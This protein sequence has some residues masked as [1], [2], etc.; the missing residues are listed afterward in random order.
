P[1]HQ[2]QFRFAPGIGAPVL[3]SYTDW[4]GGNESRLSIAYECQQ[5]W[6]CL[7]LFW[8]AMLKACSFALV[9]AGN[10]IAARM[11]IMAITTNSSIKVKPRGAPRPPSAVVRARQF[12][13]A[14]SAQTFAFI[15]FSIAVRWSEHAKSR[16]L[17]LISPISAP[18]D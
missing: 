9:R 8:H 11:A 5:I 6:S 18:F 16:E 4:F 10:N 12:R 1:G 17:Y 3:R 2:V 7:R 14:L 15:A 13:I